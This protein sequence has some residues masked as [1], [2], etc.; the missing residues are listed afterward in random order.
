MTDLRDVLGRHW[1][2]ADR[3]LLDGIARSW[4]DA[5][6]KYEVNTS[7]R[8]AHFWAQVSHECGAGTEIIEN[9]NYSADR[10]RAVWPTRPNAVQFAHN[11]RGLA[12]AVYNGRMG[13]VIGSDDGYNFRGHGLLQLTGRESYAK[14]G[15]LCGIDLVDNSA[16]AVAPD[17]AVV[18][19]VVEFV[20]LG[21]L[22]F[23]D[24]DDI[25]GVTRRVNGGFI[26]LDQRRN[27]LTIW[28]HEYNI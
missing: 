17:T 4:P 3:A 7:M 26:G 14:I 9:M 18:V 19:A 25:R 15:E 20:H 12:D 21:C 23:C 16:L 27:W 22:P 5:S 13:N 28:K 24:R 2:R 8:M 10:I 1:P 6:A 11:P